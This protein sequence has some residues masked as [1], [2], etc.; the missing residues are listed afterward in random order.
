MCH[1]LMCLFFFTSDTFD[2]LYL[3]NFFNRDEIRIHHIGINI[4][5]IQ[6]LEK[7]THLHKKCVLIEMKRRNHL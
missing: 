2:I 5:C 4:E 7:S 6:S 3:D 1:I